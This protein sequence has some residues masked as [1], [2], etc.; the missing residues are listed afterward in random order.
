MPTQLGG[1]AAPRKCRGAERA[2]RRRPRE[3]GNHYEEQARGG[4]VQ[5]K[6]FVKIAKGGGTHVHVINIIT[7]IVQQN[8]WELL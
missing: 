3:C 8:K 1:G 5:L 7:D 2:A 6:A 4:N